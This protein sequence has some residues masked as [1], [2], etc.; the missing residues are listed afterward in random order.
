MREPLT[1][2]VMTKD[3]SHNIDACIRSVRLLADES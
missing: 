2:I 1:V 3:E